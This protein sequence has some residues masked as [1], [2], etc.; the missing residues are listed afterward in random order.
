MR[1]TVPMPPSLSARVLEGDRAALARLLTRVEND[2][3]IGQQA[4][5]AL[6][7]HTGHAHLLGITGPP[8]GGKSTLVN[9]MIRAYRARRSE[10]CRHRR[11]PQQPA[12]GRRDAR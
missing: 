2:D 4:L 12:N 11:R 10:G 6:Y 9:E 7:P 3:E 1:P 5:D 8:G